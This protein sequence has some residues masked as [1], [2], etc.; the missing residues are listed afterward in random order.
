MRGKSSR[1]TLVAT[2]SLVLVL[3]LTAPAY[4]DHPP[5]NDDFDD[6]VVVAELPFD[7]QI[8]TSHA[9]TA[10]DD[11][12]CFGSGPTVWYQF[13]PTADMRVEANTFDSDYDTTLSV[14]TGTRGD[15]TQIAC[16]DDAAFTLQSRVRFD[17]EAGETYHL[18]VGA[19]FGGP[20]G[21]L[22]FRMLEA[23]PAP[24]PL[25]LEV[26]IDPVGSVVPSQGV[27]TISGTLTCSRPTFVEVF[28]TLEQ[29]AG[30][31]IIRGFFF[32]FVE[33]D[34]TTPWTAK[35]EG[36]NGLFAG[37][38]ATVEV[39]AFAFDDEEDDF[40]EAHASAQIRLRGTR[41]S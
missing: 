22:V 23:P 40:A 1:P 14:Y 27:A 18:M 6:A 9:T 32:D 30:R 15:L 29:R 8:D 35:V 17:A 19:F 12:D 13:T 2:G 28:G 34:G 39:F 3:G 24:P 33:C 26:S 10:E 7:D 16:N 11:P 20:G 25:E 21:N 4:A 36:E 41:P 37:G 5:T 38:R 31:V